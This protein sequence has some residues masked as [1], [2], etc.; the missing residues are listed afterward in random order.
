[1]A[2]RQI[3]VPGAMPARD[4]NGR[5]LPSKFR[6]YAPGTAFSVPAV[7]YSDSGLL[8]AHAFPLPSDAA[9]RWPAIWMDDSDT[10]D[11]AWTDQVNDAPQG[12]WTG[13][14]P[15][16]DAVLGSVA[17]AEAAQA[18]AETAQAAAEV[19]QALAEAAAA[20]VTGAPFS[21]TSVTANTIG[22]GTKVF[23]LD[24]PGTLF[25]EGQLVVAAVTGASENQMVCRVDEVDVDDQTL[26]LVV[27]TH[28]EPGGV[29]PY[30]TWTISLAAAGGV[31]SLA[32]LSGII[33]AAAAKAA[34]AIA[35]T[36]ITDFEDAVTDIAAGLATVL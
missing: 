11:V 10:V 18:A 26:T 12:Q 13:L 5:A 28:A 32:G 24:Q 1:M 15:A 34:L 3:I 27:A 6:F 8:V 4:R 2:A 30:A 16:D 17:L 23:V 7:V 14:S 31:T 19:A 9:G 33:T 20:M 36:D 22:A 29:G 21:A 35:S 25:F